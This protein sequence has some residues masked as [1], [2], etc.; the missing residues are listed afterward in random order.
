[1]ALLLLG[2]SCATD[3]IDT[4]FSE[5]LKKK[6][7]VKN[8]VFDLGLESSKV[9]IGEKG[10]K[11]YYERS[12]FDVAAGEKVVLTLKEFYT[13]EDLIYNQIQTL[14]TSKE[15]LQSSGVLYISFN[16]ESKKLELKEQAFLKVFIP[17][18]RL[19]GNKIFNGN[20]D[21]LGSIKWE[22]LETPQPVTKEITKL[23]VERGVTRL[24]NINDTIAYNKGDYFFENDSLAFNDYYNIEEKVVEH[25][26]IKQLQ[27][28]NIDAYILEATKHSFNFTILNDNF[29]YVNVF[30]FF[31]DYQSFISE[32][33]NTDDLIFTEYPIVKG[34]TD[35]LIIGIRNKKIYAKKFTLT[36]AISYKVTLDP[37]SEDEIL[38][39]M[40]P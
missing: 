18:N 4:S 33:R 16:T 13:L 5:Q 19:K 35:V 17:E 32:N 8:Q 25:L 15:L 10:T 31:R 1:M 21:D 24:F 22:E 37:T 23:V 9:I 39:Q 14:T 34:K 26:F 12:D 7:T 28:I 2:W 40:I 29:D 6:S 20:M 27:W 30:F 38:K 3:Q 36:N 11:I